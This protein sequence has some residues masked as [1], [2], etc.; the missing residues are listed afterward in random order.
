MKI[1]LA[2]DIHTELGLPQN[3]MTISERVDVMIL[4][5]DIGKGPRAIQFAQDTFGHQ[6]DHIVI[7]AGNHEHWGGT[8][9]KTIRTTQEYVE[10]FPNIHFLQDSYVDIDG[11]RFIGATCWTD[12]VYGALGAPLHMKQAEGGMNDYRYI[13]FNPAGSLYRKLR[14]DDVRVINWNS[15]K[16]IF[17]TLQESDR[18]KCVVVSHHAP[19]H[20]SISEEFLG[21]PLNH[22]YA[23]AWGDL[24]AWNGP[25]LWCH[26]HIHTPSDYELGDT[27]VL[28][29]PIG[30]PGQDLNT[31]PRVFEP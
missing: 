16:F 9:Q 10:Q 8:Y 20:L 4:A 24:V 26:G 21:D 11:Y 30:Y 17:D 1:G 14:A 28:C 3:D 15:K 23:N 5:G 31:R 29:N 27:R 19:C 12:F 7:I 13:K 25:K 22:C 2:S 6:A 18:E